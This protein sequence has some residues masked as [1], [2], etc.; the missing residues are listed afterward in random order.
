MLP[1]EESPTGGRTR[2]RTAYDR[3]DGQRGAATVL[4]NRKK[5]DW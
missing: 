4:T 2:L 1:K 5:D 3:I